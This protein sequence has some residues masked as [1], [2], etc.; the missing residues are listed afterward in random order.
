[1]EAVRLDLIEGRVD[2]ADDAAL[3]GG[4]GS[5]LDRISGS[6]R[7]RDDRGRPARGLRDSADRCGVEHLRDRLGDRVAQLR[8]HIEAGVIDDRL[9]DRDDRR[10]LLG[11]EIDPGPR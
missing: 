7:G 1:M 10:D 6:D 4:R 5:Q 9:G 2:V 8:P 11:D 3:R